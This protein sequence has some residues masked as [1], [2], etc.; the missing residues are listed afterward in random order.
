[1][2]SKAY[3]CT[4]RN[5]WIVQIP[6]IRRTYIRTMGGSFV[7]MQQSVYITAEGVHVSYQGTC[8]SPII[9]SSRVQQLFDLAMPASCLQGHSFSP[10]GV[11]VHVIVNINWF[12][13]QR[14]L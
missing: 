7:V 5:P 12:R 13:E 11:H 14:A 1:M 8:V 10:N 4:L 9:Q 2:D 3:N 6:K